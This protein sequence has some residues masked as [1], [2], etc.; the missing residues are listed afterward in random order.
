[1]GK[2]VHR[3]DAPFVTGPVVGYSQNPVN[4]RVPHIQVGRSHINL[5][6]QDP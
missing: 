2:I 3:V 6:P 5:G 1:M 4:H